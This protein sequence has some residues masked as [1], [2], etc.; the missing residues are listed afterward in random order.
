MTLTQAFWALVIAVVPVVVGVYLRHYLKAKEGGERGRRQ[1]TDGAATVQPP[2]VPLAFPEEQ[3]AST[4]SRQPA[5]AP[6]AEH[7]VQPTQRPGP[8]TPPPS[9]RF[10]PEAVGL[11]RPTLDSRPIDLGDYA[12]LSG[13][14]IDARFISELD[15]ASDEGGT[16][17]VYGRDS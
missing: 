7:T 8:R 9:Q 6:L 15:W 5:R 2:Q 13:S 11:D 14:K 4:E 17:T 10:T 16:W 12:G 3:S 1:P